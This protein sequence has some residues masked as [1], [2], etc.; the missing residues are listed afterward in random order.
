VTAMP[1]AASSNS[2]ASPRW[3]G[4][5]APSSDRNLTRSGYEAMRTYQKV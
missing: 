2:S 3:D 1:M 5:V 4:L